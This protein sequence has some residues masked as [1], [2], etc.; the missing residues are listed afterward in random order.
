MEPNGGSW[1]A[2]SPMDA[3]RDRLPGDARELLEEHLGATGFA[4]RAL[5]SFGA[6]IEGLVHGETNTRLGH[7]MRAF[8]YKDPV[9][10]ESEGKHVLGTYSSGFIMG[11]NFTELN[12][13]IVNRLNSDIT[14]YYP[15]WPETKQWLEKMGR[16]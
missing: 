16:R 7:I 11:V 8:D 10:S 9:L 14:R 6:A 5:A 2:A 15:M 13:L 1:D 3:L 4:L 12:M